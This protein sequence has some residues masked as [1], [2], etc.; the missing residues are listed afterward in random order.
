[1]DSREINSSFNNSSLNNANIQS[2]VLR[3]YQLSEK[4]F[5]NLVAE[6]N[7]ADI[8][9]TAKDQNR[10]Y[11]ENLK[12]SLIE[13]DKETAKKMIDWI[14]DSIGNVSSIITIASVL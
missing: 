8:S 5:Q 7:E 14:K 6:I 3:E 4:D 1:M 12:A 9:E 2:D 10:L 11:L 13:H